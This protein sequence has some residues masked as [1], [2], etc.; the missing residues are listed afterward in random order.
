MSLGL[1]SEYNPEWPNWFITLKE[2]YAEALRGL[3]IS[4]EHVGSTSV[5]GM[6]AK[7]IIDIDIVVKR[8]DFHQVKERLGTLGYIH[9]GDLG[10]PDREAFKMNDNEPDRVLPEHHLY[11]CYGDGHEVKKHLAFREYLRKHRSARERLKRLKRRL[12][13]RC[14]SRQEYID[15]KDTLVKKI[16]A[17]AL[18][19]YSKAQESHTCRS[20]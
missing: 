1:I 19:E 12:D 14:R 17:R 4:I 3:S 8:E 11:V 15:G 9:E 5:K 2:M 20:T 18:K 16:T 13:K 6:N 7:P 10:I